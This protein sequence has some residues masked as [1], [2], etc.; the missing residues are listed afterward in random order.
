[1]TFRRV[2]FTWLGAGVCSVL[3]V[4]AAGAEIQPLAQ[5]PPAVQ[6]GIQAQ[7]AN[8]TLGEIDRE[9]EDGETTYT[10][11]IT[12]AGQARDYTLSESG[13]L[14][15]MEV[16]LRELPPVVQSSIQSYVGQGKVASIDKALD[17]EAVRYDVE[18]TTKDGANRS[19]SLLENGKLE[20]TQIDFSEAPPAVQATITKEAGNGQVS[21]VVK[22]FEDNAVFYDV[23]VNRDSKDRDFTVAEGGKLESR[24]VFL[25]EL[26]PPAQTS[27]QRTIGAGKL[28]RIDQVF[29][30]KKGVF[31]FEIE[32]L[33][34]GK[35]YDFSI[36]PKGAFLG[37]DQ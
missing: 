17:D 7:L 23:T 29:D 35:P 34:D 24:Q 32:S 37:I 28:L 21:E 3:F 11:E 9:D 22:S 13:A 4:P 6:K 12:K 10:V 30:K 19:F 31:P 2:L 26:P 33:V 18:W 27:V 20:S 14:L 25:N 5:V 1:M 15:R 16:F 8:G 36:G